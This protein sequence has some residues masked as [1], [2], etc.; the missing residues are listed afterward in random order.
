MRVGRADEVRVALVDMPEVVGERALPLQQA[1][2]L[3]AREA[4]AG[5]DAQAVGLLD[6]FKR[7]VCSH[8]AASSAATAG[9]AARIDATMLT[10]P[11]QRQRLPRIAR[12]ISSSAGS[13]L[14][15]SR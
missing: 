6:R 9:A 2:V 15:R 4:L 8:R 11:V 7:R 10:Y 3:L 14:L 5:P 1:A 12:R 13:G